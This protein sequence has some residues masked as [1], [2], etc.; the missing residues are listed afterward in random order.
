MATRDR[1]DQA[2]VAHFC[3]HDTSGAAAGTPHTQPPL[4]LAP[5][6]HEGETCQST[7]EVHR[8]RLKKFW[9]TSPLSGLQRNLMNTLAVIS[10]I[11]FCVQT[12]LPNQTRY[13]EKH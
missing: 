13:V 11:Q 6:A 2:Q 1:N 9:V 7:L 8:L 4:A 3:E 12:Y 10:C 5:V